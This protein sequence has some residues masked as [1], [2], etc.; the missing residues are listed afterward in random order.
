[1]AEKTNME[2]LKE[3]IKD[4][5]EALEF[6]E[7]V[8]KEIKLLQ[9]RLELCKHDKDVFEEQYE[10]LNNENKILEEAMNSIITIDCGIG[11]IEYLEPDNIQLQSLMEDFKEKHQ[12][13]L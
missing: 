2:Y 13:H 5:D 11:I 10:I 1:M 3:F 12:V 4:N 6:W 7:A 9:K 8:N